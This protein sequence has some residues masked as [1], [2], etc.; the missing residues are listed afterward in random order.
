M[1]HA[2]TLTL[3]F[4]TP[5]PRWF[6]GPFLES[7]N[8]YNLGN[9]Y[10]APIP[11][12]FYVL[13]RNMHA[14]S[15][16]YYCNLPHFLGKLTLESYLMQYHVWLSSNAT[17]LLTIIPGYPLINALL[18]TG[19]FVVISHRLNYLTLSLRG[20]LMP[21][22]ATACIRNT[23]GMAGILAFYRVIGSVLVSS[24]FGSSGIFMT[25]A[26]SGAVVLAYI[27]FSPDVIRL[28]ASLL[29]IPCVA[30]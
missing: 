22:D 4:W 17:Q 9:A 5:P 26:A 25:S 16:K 1:S 24:G 27:F 29:Y 13:A 2:R 15:R 6:S 3:T 18:A 23:V 8:T 10:Y 28:V 20:Q 30:F 21:D 11:M 12:I 19:L 7:K 14:G